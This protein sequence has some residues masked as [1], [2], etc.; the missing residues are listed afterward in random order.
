MI[1]SGFLEDISNKIAPD[2]NFIVLSSLLHEVE[3]PVFLLENV[4]NLCSSNTV[5]H[6]N[7]PNNRK[8]SKNG[9]FM[10]DRNYMDY[11]SDRF[12]DHSLIFYDEKDKLIAG[13]PASLH[14]NEIISHGGITY[15]GIISDKKMTVQ[16]M[17][18]RLKTI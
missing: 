10:L 12:I 2:F 17:F 5:V 18:C 11:H 13:M 3:K 1:H 4:K 16:K 15:G 7:V 9:T 14:E 6:I 8:L